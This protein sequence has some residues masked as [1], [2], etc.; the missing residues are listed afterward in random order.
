MPLKQRPRDGYSSIII[1]R[2]RQVLK[3][4]CY[5]LTL[6]LLY[7]LQT[8]PA[9]FPGIGLRFLMLPFLICA[10]TQEEPLPA[11]FFGVCGGLF[12]DISTKGLLGNLAILC[13]IMALMSS[14]LTQ[15]FI[16][17]GM[18]SSCLFAGGGTAI[19]LLVHYYFNYAIWGD[20]SSAAIFTAVFWK[21]LLFNL[22]FLP[23]YAW[24]ASRIDRIHPSLRADF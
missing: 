21:P 2:R 22:P 6:M 8:G 16:K 4:V 19:V 11:F 13:G 24:I 14:L 23:V 18:L 1:K 15:L 20:A 17:R 9:F 3:W 10:A 7:I 5:F 12:W